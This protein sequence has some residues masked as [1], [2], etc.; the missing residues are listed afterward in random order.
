MTAATATAA[1]EDVVTVMT[2]TVACDGTA[3]SGGHPRVYLKIDAAS[4]E[5]E[6]P[7]CSRVFKL[8]PAA[9]IGHH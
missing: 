4:R 9:K 8:D 7:Y 3:D 5:V 6:C 1:K 2:D